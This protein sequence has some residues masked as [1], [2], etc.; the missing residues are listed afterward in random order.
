MRATSGMGRGFPHLTVRASRQRCCVIRGRRMNAGASR[1]TRRP[2][3]PGSELNAGMAAV[4]LKPE[5]RAEG[6]AGD[7]GNGARIPSPH[8]SGFPAAVDRDP[9]TTPRA[10]PHAGGAVC[11]PPRTRRGSTP[12]R[13]AACRSPA[14]ATVARRCDR[15]PGWSHLGC[16]HAGPRL[17]GPWMARQ[18][19]NQYRPSKP[20]KPPW[21]IVLEVAPRPGSVSGAAS[22]VGHWKSA[23]ATLPT[24][25]TR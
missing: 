8:G 4:S 25:T 20:A 19:C 16:D 5:A 14:A 3:W 7:V 11:I 12:R 22:S 2:C 6:D 23:W 24:P 10:S 15:P 17:P 18:P 13:A 9:F 1:R 21:M